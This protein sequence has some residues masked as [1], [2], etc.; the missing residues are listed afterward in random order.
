MLNE[1]AAVIIWDGN[2]INDALAA[3][4]ANIMVRSGVCSAANLKIHVYD[5]EGLSDALLKTVS[6]SE[7]KTTDPK[8]AV[9]KA[10]EFIGKRFEG[11]LTN[12]NG[13]YT[14]F[15]I[16]LS[17]AVNMAKHEMFPDEK[18]K[19]LLNAI[20]IIATNT[21]A[22]PTQKASKYHFNQ[23]VVDVIKNVYRL[24]SI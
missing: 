13:S 11:V 1:N 4:I 17:S 19:A 2:E 7:V 23:K 14:A 12:T 15:T 24:C 6:I 20:E 8:E 3:E 22:I 16:A 9:M 21:S 5:Q 10:I 18:D